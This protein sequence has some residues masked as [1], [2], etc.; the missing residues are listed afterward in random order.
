[1]NSSFAYLSF[2]WFPDNSSGSSN[3]QTILL[4]RFFGSVLKREFFGK[5]TRNHKPIKLPFFSVDR[6]KEKQN[7]RMH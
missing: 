2:M 5:F 1:M 6:L 3:S 4:Q 7:Y